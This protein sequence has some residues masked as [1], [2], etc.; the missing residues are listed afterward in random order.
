MV[1]IYEQERGE[2]EKWIHERAFLKSCLGRVCETNG[3][4]QVS[5]SSLN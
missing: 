3:E 2:R 1:V 5:E 4:E